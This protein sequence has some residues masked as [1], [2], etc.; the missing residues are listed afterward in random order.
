LEHIHG[1]AFDMTPVPMISIIFG[2][3]GV[4]KC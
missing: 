4:D 3:L 1:Y 2:D